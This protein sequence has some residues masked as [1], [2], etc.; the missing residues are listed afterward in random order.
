MS[1]R[2]D[3][4]RTSKAWLAEGPTELADR[5][6]DAAL[7]EAHATHQ[8]RRLWA[9]PWRNLALNTPQRVAAGIAVV[10]VVGFAALSILGRGPGY[11]AA[12]TPT[13]SAAAPSPSPRVTT[14][15]PTLPTDTA[16]W[17]HLTSTQYGYSMASPEGWLTGPAT[18]G[19]AGQT[20][21]DMWISSINAPWADKI[22]S[23]VWGITLTGLA[24][25]V[26]VGTTEETFINSYLAPP[27]GPTP[28]CNMLAKDMTPIVIDGRPGRLGAT[29]G[30]QTPALAAFVFVG[31]RMFVF[32][33]SDAT[34]PAIFNAYLSTIKLPAA[35]SPT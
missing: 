12:P 15:Q 8:R 26:P 4:E 9:L 7:R 23:A 19:W 1:T 28:T 2:R 18:E 11:G 27:P 20:S 3:F 6:L 24:A 30:D 10:A 32:A 13:P 14:P 31:N 33:E 34:Q 5:V 25:T 21:H 35:P 17:V 16:S 22:Y 29:C